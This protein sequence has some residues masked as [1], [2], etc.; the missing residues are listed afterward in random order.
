M[1]Q[2]TKCLFLSLVLL[3]WTSNGQAATE[4][5]TTLAAKRSF[6]E[7]SPQLFQVIAKGLESEAKLKVKARNAELILK[8][9]SDINR[10]GKVPSPSVIQAHLN[11]KEVRVLSALSK[12]E[13]AAVSKQIL[14]ETFAALKDLNEKLLDKISKFVI[15]YYKEHLDLPSRASVAKIVGV[16]RN[17][18]PGLFGF[19]GW[20]R[21]FDVY[22]VGRIAESNSGQDIEKLRDSFVNI[23][24]SRAIEFRRTLSEE[25]FFQGV[26]KKYP[27]LFENGFSVETLSRSLN[28]QRQ[29]DGWTMPLFLS[30]GELENITFARFG[31]SMSKVFDTQKFGVAS[32]QA[33][34]D[35]WM[36]K[37]R[38][39]LAAAA[40]SV[41]VRDE[42]FNALLKYAKDQ[43]AAIVVYPEGGLPNDLDPKLLNHPDILIIT[44]DIEISPWYRFNVLP[45][46]FKRMDPLSYFRQPGRGGP[47]GQSQIIGNP[48]VRAEVLPTNDNHIN[49]HRLFSTGALTENWYNAKF[50]IGGVTDQSGRD[51][52]RIAFLVFEKDNFDSGFDGEG[53]PNTVHPRHVVW[54][55][56]SSSFTDIGKQYTGVPDQPAKPNRVLAMVSG[57]D[58]VGRE[59][60]D[61]ALEKARILK[62]FQ[63]HYYISHDTFEGASISHHEWNDILKMAKKAKSG[64]LDL[65]AE[66]AKVYEFFNAIL[67]S[68]PDTKVIVP[69]ANHNEWLIRLLRELQKIGY[70]QHMFLISELWDAY[71]N[72]GL[73]PFDYLFY[74]RARIINES[75]ERKR[76]VQRLPMLVDPNRVILLRLGESFK[77]GQYGDQIELA[78]HGHHGGGTGKFGLTL[79]TSAGRVH[80]RIIKGHSHSSGRFNDA[81]DVG[82]SV[83]TR[84][85]FSLG[86]PMATDIGFAFF[87]M[88]GSAQLFN[89]N[90]HSLSWRLTKEPAPRDH[91]SFT[92]PDNGKKYP[93]VDVKPDRQM[94]LETLDQYRSVSRRERA[95][96]AR[97]WRSKD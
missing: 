80:T 1:S 57:D 48:Q 79:R 85:D 12:E 22:L 28:S 35:A 34:L 47:R 62:E 87:Y 32:N 92:N 73:L 40:P 91:Y 78:E 88:D 93:F 10:D 66:I 60:V 18:L 86:Q 29:K 70:P 27:K 6:R 24:K 15:K 49:P 64:E 77:L 65:E 51:V 26:L 50:V 67:I 68:N 53:T 69:V 84:P 96:A 59:N 76:L 74:H 95:D 4:C 90:P 3:S 9:S 45:L 33:I 89:W 41:M 20:T 23:Y 43:D 42:V 25:Q 16:Q 5:E 54:S 58:H 36:K 71:N 2:F 52:H 30:Y 97:S 13:R 14:Q 83:D 63:P 94:N 8:V 31:D 61:F 11:K 21:E 7:R 38:L 82:A 46:H 39:I 55:E 17:E 75:P 19:Q 72:Q 37:K 56:N 44:E 81:I